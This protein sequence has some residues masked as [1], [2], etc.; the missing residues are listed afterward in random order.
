VYKAEDQETH[1]IVAVK[2]IKLGQ[3]SEA[4]DG[5][6]RTALREIKLLQ[7]VRHPNIIGLLDVFGHKSNISL[8]FDFM[9]TDLE[10]VIKDTSIVLSPANVKSYLIMTLQGLE[11]LHINW[12]LHRDLKPNNLLIDN[13]GVLK[14]G[15][16]GLARSYGSPTKVYTHQVVTRWERDNAVK[17][18]SVLRYFHESFQ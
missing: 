8:V 9:E 14:I 1:T 11:H 17:L 12:I 7:E 3:R 6:N 15:D 13:R 4:K 18:A 2:K 5:V 10:V 16:F